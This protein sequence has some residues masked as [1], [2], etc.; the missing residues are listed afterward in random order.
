MEGSG[1]RRGFKKRKAGTGFADQARL[2]FCG[3]FY[4]YTTHAH[5]AAAQTV[6]G[7]QRKTLAENHFI[8]SDVRTN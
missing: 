6:G 7:P 3:T 4:L 2:L 8:N 1:L 5:L